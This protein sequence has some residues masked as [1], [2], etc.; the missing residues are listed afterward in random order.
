M[1]HLVPLALAP[2]SRC[3]QPPRFA[4]CASLDAQQRKW[5]FMP[6]PAPAS[7]ARPTRRRRTTSGSSTDSAETGTPVKLQACGCRHATRRRRCCCTCTARAAT[8]TPAPAASRQH[9]RAGLLGARDRLPRLRPE[10]RRA[11]VRDHAS[12]KTR[13]PP[14]PGSRQHIPSGRAT[15][16]AIRSA[17]RSRCSWPARSTDAKGLIVEGTLHLDPRGVPDMQVGLAAGDRADHAALRFGAARS[18]A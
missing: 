16:S 11:A 4:G 10:Q 12:T 13:A 17:A 9:A 8:C 15:S 6:S 2:A 14:G 3:S 5:I 18:S 1:P 7:G